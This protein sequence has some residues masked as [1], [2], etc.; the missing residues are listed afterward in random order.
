MVPVTAS[1]VHVTI[2][3]FQPYTKFICERTKIVEHGRVEPP[4]VA[5]DSLGY[6]LDI[7]CT[8]GV[9]LLKMPVSS[10]KEM[11]LPHNAKGILQ[12]QHTRKR[13]C[14]AAPSPERRLLELPI[15]LRT[16]PLVFG[17]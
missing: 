1:M 8:S 17:A 14:N 2:T 16:Q 11:R 6:G 15:H 4:L 13:F 7:S 3:A 12:V 9:V 10:C 5:V